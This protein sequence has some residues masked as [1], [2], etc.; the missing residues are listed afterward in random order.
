MTNETHHRS[1]I[2]DSNPGCH[3]TWSELRL[4]SVHLSL[5]E[6]VRVLDLTPGEVE[7]LDPANRSPIRS[8][9]LSSRGRVSS[10]SLRRHLDWLLAKLSGREEALAA[11]R[12]QNVTMDI[13]CPWQGDGGTTL[14]PVQMRAIA[15][16]GLDFAIDF[17]Y[18]DVFGNEDRGT[19][20]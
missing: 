10:R 19:G 14:W 5:E 13:L 11:L 12:L 16:L 9:A 18:V 15:A 2:D 4:R 6:V 7:D 3:E 20:A 17:T 8:F 1:P